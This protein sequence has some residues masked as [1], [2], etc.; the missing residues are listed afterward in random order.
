[1]HEQKLDQGSL[2]KATSA[3]SDDDE[4]FAPDADEVG[5]DGMTAKLQALL[6]GL[7]CVAWGSGPPLISLC[8]PSASSNAALWRR[9]QEE[10]DEPDTRKVRVLSYVLAKPE[11][12]EC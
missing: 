5:E 1:M 11:L 8:S 9:R 2:E 6:D 3:G 10:D 7:V 12:C 4:H